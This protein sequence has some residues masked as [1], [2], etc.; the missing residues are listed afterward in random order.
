MQGIGAARL[1]LNLLRQRNAAFI[2]K[3][4]GLRKST[5]NTVWGCDLGASG[6]KAVQLQKDKSSGAIE[7]CEVVCLPHATPLSEA[8]NDQ[9]FKETLLGTMTRFAEEYAV[10]QAAVVLGFS[11]PRSLGRSFDIPNFKSK[12]AEEA[13]GYEARLQIP[14]PADEI[15]YDWHTWPLAD[16]RA[17]FQ[18]ITLLAARKD[19]VAQLVDTCEGLPLKLLAVQSVCLALYNAAHA[20]FFFSNG[21]PKESAEPV[22]EV[23]AEAGPNP[24]AILEV[25][26]DSSSLIIAAPTLV[27]HRSLPTGTARLDQSADDQVKHNP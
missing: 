5:T 25:G 8:A 12:K 4:Y 20:E 10:D 17:S 16:K 27:R 2:Q 15:V 1:Q 24:I 13:I 18:Q 11:G 23:E 22:D 26:V 21:E 6:L 9:E 3:L 19:H 14:I 7:I